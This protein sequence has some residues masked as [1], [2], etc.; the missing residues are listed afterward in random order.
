MF[1]LFSQAK[2][3]FSHFDDVLIS[4]E[5]AAT[6]LTGTISTTKFMTFYLRKK[7]LFKLMDRIEAISSANLDDENRKVAE[8]IDKI[9]TLSYYSSGVIAGGFFCI[10][11]VVNNIL[12]YYLNGVKFHL[13]LAKWTLVKAEFFYDASTNSA[14]LLTF[15]ALT[16]GVYNNVFVNVNLKIILKIKQ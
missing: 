5:A 14:F 9:I 10:M 7:T 6:L 15:F 3:T 12:D 16:M 11:P 4:A 8:R 13:D 2:F 1:F